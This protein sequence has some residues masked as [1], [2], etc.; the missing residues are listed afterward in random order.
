VS[1]RSSTGQGTV[2]KRKD[3]RW[4]AAVYLDT[5][6][7]TRK[8]F[9]F[10]AQTRQEAWARLTRAQAGALRGDPV[11][12]RNWQLGAYFDHWLPIVK[13]TKSPT[14]Y[15]SYES[16]VRNYLR[17][18]LG[19][20]S[21]T[22]LTTPRLQLYL[23]GQLEAGRSVRTVQ[24]QR[25]VLSAALTRAMREDLLTRNVAHNVELPSWRRK[26]IRPWAGE[27]LQ[28][29]L[30][31]AQDEPLYPVFLLLGLY[32]LRRGEV[33]GLRWQDIDIAAGRLHIRQQLQRYGGDLHLR[34]TKTAAGERDLP[35][36]EPARR[37]LLAIRP[38]DVQPTRLVFLTRFDNP[39]E[40]GNVLRAFRR[41]S[42]KAGLP[43]ITLHHLRHTTATLLKNTGVPARDAQLILG[44]ANMHTTQQ[45]YQHADLSG[46]FR[47]L[48]Q[49][50]QLLLPDGGNERSRHDLPSDRVTAPQSG[51]VTGRFSLVAPPRLELGTQGSSA[52]QGSVLPPSL[53]KV[54][55][56]VAQRARTSLLGAAA[57]LISRQ[58]DQ[59][60]SITIR[61][62]LQ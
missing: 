5:T 60:G 44:H 21:L 29:F 41:I 38:E 58:I 36:L 26:E 62:V 20:Y 4:E 50:Q 3:G 45:L 1:R 32:G 53:K 12:A 31:I 42:R 9:R 6:S 43:E 11:P 14:T 19:S 49:L 10:Y 2:Y 22:K 59:L 17:P 15:L 24:K 34:P 51:A 57:V 56:L 55:L 25:M 35:L 52:G 13:R 23:D 47:A 46:Q 30:A 33:L 28:L 16:V 48:T 8:R 61:A 54:G 18:D 27:Q 39:I 37:A 7:G 40:G